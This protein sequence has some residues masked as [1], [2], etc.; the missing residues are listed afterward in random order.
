[1]SYF[2]HVV[3]SPLGPLR[4]VASDVGLR[5]VWLPGE[6]PDRL[7]L[8][9]GTASRIPLLAQAER[10]LAEYFAGRRREFS[11][12]LDMHGSEFERKVW[13]GLLGIPFGETWYYA[14]LAEAIGCPNGAR[15]VGL[16]NSRNPLAIVVPCHRVIGKNGKLV[17]FAA[18]LRTKEYLLEL[19][20]SW[21]RKNIERVQVS[22][23][24]GEAAP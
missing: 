24:L 14:Q 3:P 18:G 2:V 10:E 1:M 7:P 11:I 12:P 19:E 4:R 21:R 5:R 22:M 16:A 23:D 9:E 13:H 15:A 6:R 17:G 20:G 8:P